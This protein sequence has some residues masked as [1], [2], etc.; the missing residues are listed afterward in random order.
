MHRGAR[1]ML[2]IA[3][4]VFVS[5]AEP[6]DGMSSHVLINVR[7][8]LRGSNAAALV[9]VASHEKQRVKLTVTETVVGELPSELDIPAAKLNKRDVE[10]GTQ[11]LVFFRGR[12]PTGH[13]EL[14][15]EG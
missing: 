12:Q 8:S 9:T 11:L 5:Q 6:S 13:Y 4:A 7:N 3:L 14:V 15:W 10:P 2:T 1:M